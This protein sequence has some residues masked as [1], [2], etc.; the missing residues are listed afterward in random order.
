MSSLFRR[1]L[2]ELESMFIA[3][4]DDLLARFEQ[5]ASEN[6]R[7]KAEVERLTNEVNYRKNM[8]THIKIMADQYTPAKEGK[9]TA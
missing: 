4:Q 3:S 9:P 7:L 8:E 5:T 2:D 1:K 6:A